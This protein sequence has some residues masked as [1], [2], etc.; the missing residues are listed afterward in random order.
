[1]RMNASGCCKRT[2][3]AGACD[4]AEEASTGARHS[5]FLRR[6]LELL[7]W[8]APAAA[9]ALMPKCPLCI[10]AYIA[11]GTG[12]GVSVATAAHIR[13]LLLAASMAALAYLMV[14]RLSRLG[15]AKSRSG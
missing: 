10:A 3:K 6:S 9:L 5:G 7:R 11:V 14:R 4:R 1:M 8:L 15:V 2:L 13:W 12:I